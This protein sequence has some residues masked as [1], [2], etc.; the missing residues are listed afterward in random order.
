MIKFN[1]Y[2]YD[3]NSRHTFEMNSI[4]EII[5]TYGLTEQESKDFL[6]GYK[7][8]PDNTDIILHL[9]YM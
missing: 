6:K 4:E 8:N 3:D 7:V 1:L 2:D 9:I 5:E